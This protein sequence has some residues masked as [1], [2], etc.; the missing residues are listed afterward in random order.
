MAVKTAPKGLKQAIRLRGQERQRSPTPGWKPPSGESGSEI[1]SEI[2]A[3]N[4]VLSQP[5]SVVIDRLLQSLRAERNARTK[6]IGEA[7]NK[8]SA[9]KQKQNII[10]AYFLLADKEVSDE[11]L[12]KARELT[13]AAIDVLP[14]NQDL[15]NPQV[16]S[17]ELKKKLEEKAKAETTT[18]VKGFLNN[19]KEYFKTK[20][21][22]FPENDSTT[23]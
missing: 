21:E 8:L 18:E 13:K 1:G 6:E 22:E 23:S 15:K 11:K 20:L 4:H 12:K 17:S 9:D 19:A 5:P 16:L 14:D 2:Y 10:V 3:I 7:E